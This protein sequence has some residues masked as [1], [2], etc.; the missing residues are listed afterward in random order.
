MIN[1]TKQL[2]LAL[3]LMAIT[4]PAS[5][6]ELVRQSPRPVGRRSCFGCSFT[7]TVSESSSR[8]QTAT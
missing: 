8:T 7:S 6:A 5:S 1:F 4:F 2:P 3:L